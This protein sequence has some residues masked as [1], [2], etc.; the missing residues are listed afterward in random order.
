MRI[1]KL[2]PKDIDFPDRSSV[3][4]YFK[5]K[6]PQRNPPGQFLLTQS[7]I[8]ESGIA[9]GELIIFSYKTEITHIAKSASG[10]LEYPNT[11]NKDYP[12]YFIVDMNTVCSAKGNLADVEVAL[13]SVGIHKN[14]VRSQGWPSIPN[15]QAI[16][17][18]W[19][20]LK[21]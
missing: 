12:F 14:I 1:I 7:R 4:T 18:I 15:S 10:R 17:K 6:L 16:E 8:A 11:G 21:K 19:N 20:S 9:I 3:S 13:S 5:I 2:S